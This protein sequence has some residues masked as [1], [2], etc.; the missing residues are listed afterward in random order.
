[1]RKATPAQKRLKSV[2]YQTTAAIMAAGRKKRR[3]F[4]MTIMMMSP[5]TK[6]IRSKMASNSNPKPRGGSSGVESTSFRFLS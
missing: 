2:R 1:M 4:A 3:T 5:M 6:R